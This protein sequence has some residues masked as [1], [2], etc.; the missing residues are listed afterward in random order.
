MT[1]IPPPPPPPPTTPPT[2]PLAAPPPPPAPPGQPT[3]ATPTTEAIP[4]VPTGR[5][6]VGGTENTHRAD[7]AIVSVRNLVKQ[8]GNFTAVNNISFDVPKGSIFGLIGPNGAGKST[9]FSVIA[10]LLK[11]TTGEA[12]VG[13]FDPAVSPRDVRRLIGYMPDQ[14]GVYGGLSAEEYLRFYAA[15]YQIPKNDWPAL[16]DGLLELVGLSEKRDTDIDT[17]SRGMKQRMSLARAL[18]HDPEVLILDEPA[19]GLDPRARVELRELIQQLSSMGKTIIISSHILSEL[20]ELCTDIAII[21]GGEVL[22]AGTPSEIARTLGTNR[23][24]VTFG[25]GTTAEYS[26][27]DND[28]QLALLRDLVLNDPRGVLAFTPTSSNL[29]QLFMSVTEGGVR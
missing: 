2:S 24:Q 10:S 7:N 13:G 20:Q 17:M 14:L 16:V 25:D 4:I 6:S 21:E 27:V 29:E 15:A 19:S 26:V 12:R 11:P 23:V 1:T 8:Y 22:A 5:E 9:T 18:V 28:E 3:Q